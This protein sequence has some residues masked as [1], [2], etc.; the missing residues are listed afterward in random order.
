MPSP[1]VQNFTMHVKCNISFILSVSFCISARLIYFWPLIKQANDNQI[2]NV[3]T[4]AMLEAAFVLLCQVYLSRLHKVFSINV[5]IAYHRCRKQVCFE[6]AK[7]NAEEPCWKLK[8][9]N[10]TT[11]NWR[12]K[13]TDLCNIH[14][15]LNEN[16]I[17]NSS[18]KSTLN[19]L[20]LP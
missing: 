20:L 18:F 17:S 11:V 19:T 3:F 5:L 14:T 2:V 16:F 7:W 6:S 9:I 12:K 4:P 13:I 8:Q 15:L 1:S 10:F